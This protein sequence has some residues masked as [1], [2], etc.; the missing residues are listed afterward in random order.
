MIRLL[1]LLGLCLGLSL[2]SA[3]ESPL[4]FIVDGSGS[5][6]QKI[7]DQ[8]KMDI[9]REVLGARLSGFSADRPVG[10]VAYGHR[11]TDDCSDI[12]RLVRAEA[13]S[14]PQVKEE[15]QRLQPI[16]KTPLA[17]T[18]RMVIDELRDE[19]RQATV[20]LLT[21]GIESCD[22]DLCQVVMEAR[23]AGIEFRLH[24][25][26][27]G[28][29]KGEIDNLQCAA[30]A[31][32][33]RYFDAANAGELTDVLTT[34]TSE[35]IDDPPANLGFVALRNG[36][37]VDASVKLR[38]EPDGATVSVARTY[39][40]TAFVFLEPGRYRAEV[41]ALDNSD[42]SP[43]TL[44]LTVEAGSDSLIHTISFDAGRLHL[45]TSSNGE[46]WDAL[47]RVYPAGGQG[48]TVAQTRT[49]GREQELELDPGTY[50]LHWEAMQI[51]GPG[52]KSVSAGVTVAGGMT[53]S[54]QHDFPAGRL[55]I[56]ARAG[57]DLVDA[58]VKILSEDGDSVAS[59]RTYTRDSSNPK[60]FIL[61]PGRYHV[62]LKPLGAYK[63]R[64]SQTLILDIETGKD[65]ERIVKF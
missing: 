14:L 20:I 59:G 37:P 12:E 5:M 49:Y 24:I 23:E 4:I 2:L 65:L 21:D 18:A 40:D 28:L 50:D 52:S 45:Y 48:R 9:A 38:R 31:G 63:D 46:G 42:L 56:G 22:G 6:W 7:G 27:F 11:R 62:V 35:T 15:L 17:A 53:D 25:I 41:S 32:S 57:D 64:A 19:G 26:G 36:E 54:L 55:H 34:T 39:T 33:G 61:S 43:R 13:G 30:E 44:P 51:K 10:L 47:V 58:V 1:P 16:G 29:K 8:T 3:Q 60:T